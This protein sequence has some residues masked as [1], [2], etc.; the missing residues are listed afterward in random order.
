MRI[1]DI[2]KE[3]I[4]QKGI[5]Q[6]YLAEK[7]GISETNLSMMLNGNTRI[8]ADSLLKIAMVIQFDLNK[9]KQ[10]YEKRTP[11]IDKEYSLKE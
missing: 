10:I 6:K 4:E 2:L 8:Y 7:T 11:T 5:K 3:D 9:L 1:C